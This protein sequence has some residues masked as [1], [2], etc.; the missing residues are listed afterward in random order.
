MKRV[1]CLF[2]VAFFLLFAAFPSF[3]KDIITVGSESEERDYTEEYE[4]ALRGK[5]K[6]VDGVIDLIKEKFSEF[7][8][9]GVNNASVL[10]ALLLLSGL[11]T[12]FSKSTVATDACNFAIGVTFCIFVFQNGIVDI[13]A[14][15]SMITQLSETCSALIPIEASLLISGQKAASAVLSGYSSKVVIT[16]CQYLFKNITLPLLSLSLAVVPLS[17]ISDESGKIGAFFG[18]CSTFSTV[19]AVSICG[20]FLSL[21][22][23]LSS[24]ADSVALRSVKF[25]VGSF[26]PMVGGA[27]GDAVGYVAGGFSYI[28]ST[29]GIMAV[30]A[31]V[32][33]TLPYILKSAFSYAVLAVANA[34]SDIISP[35]QSKITSSLL[36]VSAGILA[37]EISSAVLFILRLVL[38]IKV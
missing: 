37:C 34:V 32:G 12:S 31:V 9:Y 8:S 22:S 18:K 16:L 14:A 35:A 13:F 23:T 17:Q 21:R 11:F 4:N 36:S 24:A 7:V 27:L 28:K 33:V 19:S 20:F 1:L 25:A 29:C 5:E 38:F 26:V 2:T 30:C 15:N 6:S 10:I 3:S